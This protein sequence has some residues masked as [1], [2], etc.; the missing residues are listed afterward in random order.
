MKEVSNPYRDNL[1]AAHSR[2]RALEEENKKLK[3][4]ILGYHKLLN[5][6]Y[7]VN[8]DYKKMVKILNANLP[9]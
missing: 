6:R 7:F 3:Y 8:P 5:E 4:Q 2:I 9:K 1:E